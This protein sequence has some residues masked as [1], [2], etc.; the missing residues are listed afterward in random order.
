VTIGILAF[1]SII[2]E[3]GEELAASQVDRID[4][5]ETP[6]AVEF[7]RES[8]TRDGAPTLVPVT[9]G[10]AKIAG[11][12]LVLDRSINEDAARDM[13]YRREFRKIGQPVRYGQGP[14]GCIKDIRDFAGLDLCIFTALAAN[15]APLTAERL[16]KLAIQSA[17]APAG[18]RRHDGISYLQEQRRRG[19]TTPL[20]RA[21]ETEILRKTGASGLSD[22]WSRAR[23]QTQPQP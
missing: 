22:A 18:S 12:V 3:P 21:Y 14:R 23:N 1:G 19:I 8:T 11:A 17:A 10:G 7:A 6:F 5:V 20:M 13:L 9:A 15:I 4:G 16:A 2:E